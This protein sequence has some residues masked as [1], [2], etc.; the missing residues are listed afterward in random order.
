M[1]KRCARWAVLY[2]YEDCLVF[3]ASDDHIE[4]SPVYSHDF[5]SLL[6]PINGSRP[7]TVND[8]SHQAFNSIDPFSSPF[9]LF[10]SLTLLPD[11]ALDFYDPPTLSRPVQ[12]AE[13]SRRSGRQ[14][15]PG[16]FSAA[17]DPV[18]PK[19]WGNHGFLQTAD[20]FAEGQHP[21][22]ENCELAPRFLFVPE[23][24]RDD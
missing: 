16:I 24:R 18:S 17:V 19:N 14:S 3:H 7:L 23:T 12:Q 10:I 9:L 8:L 5:A 15:G 11:A 1:A 21:F 6:Q 4:V 20:Y 22:H 13:N 2:N